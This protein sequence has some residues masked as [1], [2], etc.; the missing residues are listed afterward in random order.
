MNKPTIG[1]MRCKLNKPQLGIETFK[2]TPPSNISPFIHPK[3]CKKCGSKNIMGYGMV[4][5]YGWINLDDMSVDE[6]DDF[7]IFDEESLEYICQEEN[8]GFEWE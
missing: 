1:I 8:C 5:G 3:Q 7:E 4:T 2:Y 6:A